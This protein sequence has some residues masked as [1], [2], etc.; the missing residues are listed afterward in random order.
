MKKI[1]ILSFFALA[2]SALAAGSF[3][4]SG[5]L[6]YAG[7][8]N[9][10][11]EASWDCQLFQ[12]AKG[13]LRPTVDLEYGAGG[14]QGAFLMRHVFPIGTEGLGLG[15]GVGLR[16]DAGVQAYLRG[17]LEYSLQSA[18]DLPLIAGADVGY[19][20]GFGGAPQEVVAHLKFG[21]NFAF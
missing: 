13:K 15:G 3:T 12:P 6:G 5:S 2:L 11:I 10:G 1:L 20:Y 16:Y 21:Y 7:G 19:A 9:G 18:L 14:F 4:V 8:I 17:D